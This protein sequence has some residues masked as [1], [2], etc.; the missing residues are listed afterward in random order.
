MEDR[1]DAQVLIVQKRCSE[2]GSNARGEL[3]H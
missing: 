1:G 3:A 2:M